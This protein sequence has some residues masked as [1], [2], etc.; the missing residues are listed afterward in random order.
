[1]KHIQHTVKPT[2][3]TLSSQ[4]SLTPPGVCTQTVSS[5]KKQLLH[6]KKRPFHT[7]HTDVIHSSQEF[8]IIFFFC[9]LSF[10]HSSSQPS[11][12]I[13]WTEEPPCHPGSC[14]AQPCG[15]QRHLRQHGLLRSRSHCHPQE[16]A[17]PHGGCTLWR[18]WYRGCIHVLHMV[19]SDNIKRPKQTFHHIDLGCIHKCN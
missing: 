19:F 16:A 10:A 15:H 5:F 4:T 2:L 8:D 13:T 6:L 1:M 3:S 11:L 14:G 17:E 18:S 9:S 7:S 12:S